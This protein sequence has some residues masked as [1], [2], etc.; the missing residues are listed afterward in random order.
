MSLG[1]LIIK[2]SITTVIAKHMDVVKHLNSTNETAFDI[3]NF[4]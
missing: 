4:I 2:K 1:F 3:Y